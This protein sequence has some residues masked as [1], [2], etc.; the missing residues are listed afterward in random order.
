V[1]LPPEL[2]PGQWRWLTEAEVAALTQK[3]AAPTALD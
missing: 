2:L 3:V 1:S